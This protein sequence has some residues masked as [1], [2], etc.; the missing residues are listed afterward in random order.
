MYINMGHNLMDYNDFA[1]D[2]LTFSSDDQNKFIIDAM[3]GYILMTS[4]KSRLLI[5]TRLAERHGLGSEACKNLLLRLHPKHIDSGAGVAAE[6][7]RQEVDYHLI[8]P[9]L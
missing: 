9:I 3:F 7:A 1:K 4:E 5:K 8:R 2:S 6:V